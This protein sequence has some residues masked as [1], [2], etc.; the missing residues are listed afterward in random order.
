MLV[1]SC[2]R[3]LHSNRFASHAMSLQILS[4]AVLLLRFAPN[5][6]GAKRF[7]V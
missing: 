4:I 7:S 3:L 2:I 6:E 1:S 5:R